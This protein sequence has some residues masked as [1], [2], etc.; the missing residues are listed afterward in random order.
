MST[1]LPGVSL[2]FRSDEMCP[3][4][5]HLLN[6]PSFYLLPVGFFPHP[7]KKSCRHSLTA[8]L[9]TLFPSTCPVLVLFPEGFTLVSF[10]PTPLR[11]PSLTPRASS[12][13]STTSPLSRY[14]PMIFSAFI[15]L[16]YAAA[17]WRLRAGD[18]KDLLLRLLEP[19]STPVC[20]SSSENHPSK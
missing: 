13:R 9:P 20:P 12:L 16:D 14:L 17:G 2:S 4:P 18:I 10:F 6:G 19:G 3:S 8:K 5:F 1:I 15:F 11:L 7:Q